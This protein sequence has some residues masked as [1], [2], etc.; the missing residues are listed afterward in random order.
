MELTK[1]TG[2]SELLLSEPKDIGIAGVRKVEIRR[3]DGKSLFVPT[4]KCFSYGVKKDLKYGTVSMSLVLDDG[5]VKALEDV[6]SQCEEHLGKTLSNVLYRRNDGTTTVYAKLRMAK[7]KVLSKFY[8]DGKEID[9]LDYEGK[10]CVVKAVLAIEG[11]ILSEGRTNLQV[12]VYEAMVRKKIYEH[13][14]LL[15]LEW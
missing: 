14:R 3:K 9:P 7:G 12:K 15:D 11:V 6:I 10:H 1:I 2:L 8:E 5:V 13:V 4:G